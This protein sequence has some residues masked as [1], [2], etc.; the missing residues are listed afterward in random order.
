MRSLG[1][2]LGK[3]NLG[4]AVSDS[5]GEIAVPHSVLVLS[6]NQ[7]ADLELVKDIVL[8][9]GADVVV[10]GF[11]LNLKGQVGKAAESAQKFVASLQEKITADVVL[12][13]E[14][15][16]T[17]EANKLLQKAGVSSKKS[18]SKVDM[19]AAAII[20]QSWLD[21]NKQQANKV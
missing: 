11:P 9:Q 3:K 6:G 13:D 16:S 7:K 5:D 10:V 1:L 19:L 4:I 17:T 20:L 12:H 8:E 18:R 14:R 21:K 2:D 15:F